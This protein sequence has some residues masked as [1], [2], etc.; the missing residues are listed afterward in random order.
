MPP[1]LLPALALVP[2]GTFVMGSDRGDDDERPAHRVH[3]DEFLIGV[4]PVSNAEYA[5]FVRATGHRAPAIYELPLVVVAGG[6]ERER[7]Y[8]ATGQPYI[9]TDGEPPADRLDHPVTL[10]RW[11]DAAA[12]CDWLSTATGRA[13]RLPTEAEWEKAARGG[14]DGAPYPWGEGLDRAHS[15]FLPDPQLRH[16]RGTTPRGT[17]AANP[18]GL[19]D[20]AGNVW[21]WVQD[22]YAPRYYETAPHAN[23][24]GPDR[25]HMRIV[26]GGSWLV[27]DPAMLSCSH[28]HQVPPDTYSYAIGFRVACRP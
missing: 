11:E 24:P 13:V 4:H 17:F 5:A 21:E 14:R 22:W 19:H 3:L 10:V 16:A 18:Y 15:N 1:D 27:I 26:R 28:R 20:V 7:T 6:E 8:R 2:A 9:W 25:G 12:Y 23:P